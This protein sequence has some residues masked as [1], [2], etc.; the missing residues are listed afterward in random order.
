MGEEGV[1]VGGAGSETFIELCSVGIEMRFEGYVW[2]G[3]EG[4]GEK[5]C[6]I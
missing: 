6:K 3:R 4:E 2:K 1:V 5:R